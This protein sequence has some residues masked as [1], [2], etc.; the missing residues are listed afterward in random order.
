MSRVARRLAYIGGAVLATLLIGTVGFVVIEGY[1]PFDAFYMTLTT[2]TTVGYTEVH[3][4]SQVGRI[5]NSV[6]ILFGVTTLFL[7]IGAMTQTIIELEL[8]EYFQK[9]RM[10][11]MIDKL[12]YHFIVCGYGR[13]G[14]G[15]AYELQRAG[16]PSVVV[17]RNPE[18][19]ERAMKAGMLAVV[20]DS[21][22]DETLQEVR[23]AKAKGL[24]AALATD[25]D[26]LFVILSAKSLNPALLVATRAV[27][28]EAERK[29]RNAGADAVFTPYTITGY[30]LSQ[31]LLRPHVYQFLDFTSK[32]LGLDVDIEQ[33]HVTEGS[34]F[35]SRSLKETQIRRDLGVIVLAIRKASG[36]M[37]FNPPAD[38][39]IAAGDYLI[40]MGEPDNLRTLERLVAEVR[41]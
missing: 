31:A 26:N 21:T 38:A 33:V 41:A 11:R 2:M 6:L 23:V 37:L 24:I 39:E 34:E 32:N 40:V 15:A 22:R 30:R 29:L 7:A 4:L 20:A 28:E 3:P 8:D 9:R 19:V 16:V 10:K 12:E 13:V 18:R 14:R 27:E 5:F 17:D 1:P 25:A 36:E 35:A